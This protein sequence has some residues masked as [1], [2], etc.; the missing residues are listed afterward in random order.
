VADL[1]API[2]LPVPRG[3]S[4]LPNSW[5]VRCAPVGLPEACSRPGVVQS[6]AGTRASPAAPVAGRD[7]I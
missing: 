3:Q 6:P 4:R 5:A 1:D 7:P 2:T